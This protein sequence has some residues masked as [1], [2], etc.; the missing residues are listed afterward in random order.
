M[1]TLIIK[2]LVFLHIREKPNNNYPFIK[3][4]KYDKMWIKLCKNHYTEKYNISASNWIDS[5]KPMFE[6]I[7]GYNPDEHLGSFRK[8]IFNKLFKIASKV[9]N[10]LNANND[11]LDFKS[12]ILLHL[13]YS[14]FTKS[15]V[16]DYELPIERG[17][18]ELCGHLQGVRVLNKDGSKRFNLDTV[19]DDI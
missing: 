5:L 1:K 3:L 15:I 11:N 16:R 6:E 8:C 14:T 17:I 4:T 9:D 19:E 7:Y 10:R 13:F 12:D 18:A 2:L